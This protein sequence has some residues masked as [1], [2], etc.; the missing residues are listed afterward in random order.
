MLR[1]LKLKSVYRSDED[2]ILEDFY[3]PCLSHSISYDRAVGYFSAAM[4][5][6]AAQ[7]IAAL[8]EKEGTMRL[9]VGG[10]ITQDESDAILNGYD[11]RAISERL[12]AVFCK[13]IEQVV[14][15][16]SYARLQALS[17]MIAQGSLS[18]KVALKRQG[19]YHEKIGVFRDRE[20]D[21]IVFQGS[22]LCQH[23]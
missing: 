18:V 20:G 16:L 23:D 9:I 17:W 10:E 6:Y 22:P 1:E 12:G 7:G 3:I 14:E 5:S 15:E 21:E 8:I 13:T 2:S 11:L 4:L 19:M